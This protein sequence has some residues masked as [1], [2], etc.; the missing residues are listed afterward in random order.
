MAGGTYKH[1]FLCYFLTISDFCGGK[2]DKKIHILTTIFLW[3]QTF[4]SKLLNALA[5]KSFQ[6]QH[7]PKNAINIHQNTLAEWKKI[8][9][10]RCLQ[11]KVST[12]EEWSLWYKSHKKIG[13]F[14]VGAVIESWNPPVL[15][16]C[17]VCRRKDASLE[18]RIWFGGQ[19][20][21]G[22]LAELEEYSEDIEDV[23]DLLNVITVHPVSQ[24]WNSLQ[25]R[26][27]AHKSR[28]RT[29]AKLCASWQLEQ[30][31]SRSCILQIKSPQSPEEQFT[32]EN[33]K[34][35]LQTSKWWNVFE[36]NFLQPTSCRWN[37]M[38]F[39]FMSKNFR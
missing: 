30:Q 16:I 3:N 1:I 31:V 9:W 17:W 2:I 6:S 38:T 21:F 13:L 12:V 32:R 11:E 23:A 19:M 10:R 34:A 25:C 15:W 26:K 7:D 29:C 24:P 35:T 37:G 5:N 18:F 39:Q 20:T 4:L 14:L 27:Y 36:A 22:R 33:K 28:L 8:P